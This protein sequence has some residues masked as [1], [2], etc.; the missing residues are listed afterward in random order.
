MST[1]NTIPA[2][3]CCCG[4]NIA[5]C[6]PCQKNQCCE[7]AKQYKPKRSF[8]LS[9][10]QT[11]FV[12]L[13]FALPMLYMMVVGH[14]PG[15]D[16][17]AFALTTPVMLIGGPRFFTSGWAAFKNHK[18]NM[19]TLIAVGTLTAY[20]YSIYALLQGEHVYFEIAA[21][22]IVFILLGQV[23]EEFTKGRASQAVEKLLHLQAKDALV[24]RGNKET[25]IPLAEL[26]VGDIIIVKPGEKVPTDGEVVEGES[27]IDESLVTGESIPVQ[28]KAGDAVIGAS[29]NTT[30]S[31]RFKATKV[32]GETLLAQ[33]VELVKQAQTSQA[34]I[35]RL[36]DRISH[37]FVPTVLVLSIVT[38]NIWFGLIGV[39]FDAALLFAVAVV[40]I[41]CPCALGLATPTALMVGVGL[42][43]RKG[44][45]I[46]SG[47][48]LEKARAVKTIVFDKTGT[49]TVGKPLVTDVIGSKE[50][51]LTVAASLEKLS[52][53]PLALAVIDAAKPYKV[54]ATTGF[55]AHEGK[56]VSGKVEGI[57]ALVGTKQ[58]LADHKVELTGKLQAEWEKLQA[59]AKTVVGVAHGGKLL[60][61]IAIQDAPK[62]SSKTAIALL[63]SQGY[64]TIMLTGDNQQTAEAVARE[65]GIDTVIA[66]V[67]PADKA[68]KV[69]ELQALA[70]VGFVGDGIND[71]P[72]LATAHLGIAM[73]SGTDVAIESGD[74]VL[75][76]NDLMDVARALKLSRKTFARIKQNLFWAFIY[77]LVGI[78]IAAGIFS[79]FGLVL[80]PALAGLAMAFS[81]VSVVLS[82]LLLARTKLSNTEPS[83]GK[84]IIQGVTALMVLIILAIGAYGGYIYAAT[85]AVVR[86][87]KLEHYHFRMQILVDGKAENF[88][89]AKYQQ[90]YAKDQ[91]SA[92]IPE[93]P[94]H[95]HDNKD[96]FTHIHWEGMTGGM[97]LKYY[98]WN[99]IGG[100]NNALGYR[101][102]DLKEIRKIDI[103]GKALPSIPSHHKLY[104]YTGDENSYKERSFED[105]KK[106]DLEQFFGTT[107]NFPAHELNKQKTSLLDSVFPKA[108]AHGLENDADSN[109]AAETHEEK[110]TRINNL[111]GNVV[112]FAQEDKPTDQ[113]IEDRF[114]NLEP[115][116]ESTCGG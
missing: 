42:G 67:M 9:L 77:N 37:Y 15:G 19:D 40:V 46:K 10:R 32:G 116:S 114:N 92:L 2:D 55:K 43:A 18:A 73:G 34:P 61:L 100:V 35:Q 76:K 22:L 20:T 102:D 112:I 11:F 16:W 79:S 97:A 83:K 110:L 65:V 13:A 78:P 113:Q 23:L 106:Q 75:V 24:V 64:K 85:P 38:F 68:E 1:A 47:E 63:R 52:E 7:A 72:A 71:A 45:L 25:R 60:G 87:P 44:I 31:F 94:I 33:I 12:C 108:Y 66:E 51:V 49:I 96:Q 74:I 90:D 6:K 88:S 5:E 17:T 57:Q 101:L 81:S 95:F 86:N 69:R 48:V 62:E 111:V 54:S 26:Q 14:I 107:S 28:K 93:Q 91:C 82:S 103:H 41:A 70:P 59:A 50:K 98:G 8:S 80:N 84:R 21:L 99:R 27:Y 4:M 29:L 104:I 56:G 109:D 3:I 53:H 30:G 58:L 115:L 89:E 39:P 36:V 105:F